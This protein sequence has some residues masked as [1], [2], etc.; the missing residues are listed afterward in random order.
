MQFTHSLS[1]C[2]R[3]L[4]VFLALSVAFAGRALPQMA[5]HFTASLA[6]S[7][8]RS[9]IRSVVGEV[10]AVHPSAAASAAYP[11]E[12]YAGRDEAGV[13]RYLQRAFT[14]EERDLLRKQFGVEEPS[15]LYLSDT[16]PGASLTYDSDWDRGERDLV[17]TYRVGAPSVRQPGETWEELERRLATTDPAGFPRSTHHADASLA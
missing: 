13:P 15:R 8:L 3:T 17:G 4:G 16:L 14:Q 5:P 1:R 6:A 12:S 7:L 10:G 2:A 9:P 11:R